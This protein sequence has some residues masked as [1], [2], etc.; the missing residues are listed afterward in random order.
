MAGAGVDTASP[1]VLGGRVFYPAA[2]HSSGP[3]LFE[4]D[5]STAGTGLFDP[6]IDTD[7]DGSSPDDPASIKSTVYF[8]AD[9]GADG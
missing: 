4:S 7:D 1:A 8:T 2:D 3:D 6:N 5:G 9:D